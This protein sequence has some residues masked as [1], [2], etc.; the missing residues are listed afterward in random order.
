[1][2]QF[3]FT[4]IGC[5]GERPEG[6]GG[7]VA[8]GSH[9][10]STVRSFLSAA[11]TVSLGS[12]LQAG[13]LGGL[14]QSLWSLVRNIDALGLF[15]RRRFPPPGNSA[16]AGFRGMDI[17]DG[18]GSYSSGARLRHRLAAHWRRLDSSIRSFVRCHSDLA[19]SHVAFYFKS[20]RRAAND[21]ASLVEGSGVE[22]ILHDDVT[23][24]M[25][26]SVGHLASGTIVAVLGTVLAAHN[27]TGASSDDP[28]SD[29][30][31][32]E[33]VLLSYVMSYTILFTVLEPLRAAIKAV[34]VCFAETPVS[35]RA[36]FPLIYQRL[37]RIS[38]RDDGLV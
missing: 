17:G 15:V 23:T 16:A 5:S 24:H 22:S 10:S 2:T 33:T 19:M 21:V 27:R 18:G 1:M 37:S 12:V 6:S 28:L 3:L 4:E 8:P 36:A 35:L 38:G 34:Y 11:C 14:A 30:S 29:R 25:A 32:L 13:L 9:S 7:D 20:Y 31:L 26:S